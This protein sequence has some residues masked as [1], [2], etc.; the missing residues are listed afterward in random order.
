M[1][2]RLLYILYIVLF[3]IPSFLFAQKNYIP[4]PDSI[5]VKFDKQRPFKYGQELKSKRTH[6]SKTFIDDKTGKH[7]MVLSNGF[8]HYQ[9][10]DGEFQDINRKLVPVD[11]AHYGV[12]EGM[13]YASFAKD[14]Q[15]DWPFT[16][17]TRDSSFIR[18]KLVSMVYFDHDKKSYK[19]V[20]KLNL[21]EPEP[22]GNVITYYNI[23][24]AQTCAWCMGTLR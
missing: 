16:V 15:A 9:G 2:N 8:M 3:L 6:F 10:A 24:R 12:R 4:L 5:A 18:W 13:F 20:Y 22:V 1:K 14:L 7:T 21:S 17:M 11:S 23:F 19:I